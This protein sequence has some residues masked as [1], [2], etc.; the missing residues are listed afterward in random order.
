M[1]ALVI[2]AA[3]T[4]NFLPSFDGYTLPNLQRIPLPKFD[5]SALPELLRGSPPKSSRV[6]ASPAPQPTPPVPVPDPVARAALIDIQMSQQQH[7]TVLASL[8]Q[9]SATLQ[10]DMKRISRQLSTLSAQVESLQKA[11]APLT[12][13]SITPSHPRARIIRAARKPPPEQPPPLP[14]PVGPVSIGGAPL[15]PSPGSGA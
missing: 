2:V 14:K 8:T 1:A 3:A 12:T 9:N 5:S 11:A 10:T 7:A 13:S 6:A 4:A 15:G